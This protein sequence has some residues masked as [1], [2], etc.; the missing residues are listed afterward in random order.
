MSIAAVSVSNDPELPP[1]YDEKNEKI[2]HI[3]AILLVTNPND[4][5]DVKR[6]VARARYPL[7]KP[8][9]FDYVRSLIEREHPTD[10]V[11]CIS[12]H[13]DVD[14]RTETTDEPT[15]FC[16]NVLSFGMVRY[17]VDVKLEVRKHS[18]LIEGP[19]PNFH[20]TGAFV[21]LLS[22]K[23]VGNTIMVTSITVIGKL[24]K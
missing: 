18:L 10:V 4:P 14:P 3:S 13:G 9:S 1:P 5:S 16:A 8:Y 17:G 2:G 22:K 21:D 23:L 11:G 7:S 24:H 6:V 20:G 15:I 19:R 12:D